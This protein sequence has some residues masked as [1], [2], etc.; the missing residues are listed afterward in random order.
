VS[1]SPDTLVVVDCTDAKQMQVLDTSSGKVIGKIVH[2]A[3]V[4]NVYLNQH[5][6][7]PQERLLAYSDRNRDLFI[8]ALHTTT[9]TIMV[10]SGILNVPTYKLNSHVESFIFNDETNVL[11][12]LADGRIKFWYHPDVAFIDKDLL[13]LTT[14]SSEATEYGRSAQILSYTGNRVSVRKVDGSILF[15]A[16]T[17]DVQ[18]L[19]ELSRGGKWDECTRLCRHQKSTFL[20]AT[21]SSMALSKKQLDT[22]EI[23]LAELNE[24]AKVEYI[25]YI[26]KIPSEEGRQAEL[27]LYRRQP[28]EAEK[29]LLQASPPLIYR[30]IKLNINLF[31]WSRAVDLAVKHKVHIDT[32]LA[33]RQKYLDE[34]QREETNQKFVQLFEKT[35]IDW[36]EIIENEEKELE[37]E[38][39]RVN[40]GGGRK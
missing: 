7:G 34:F 33:Y 30:A 40:K 6:L 10:Q 24:V 29:I 25:Q 21:L 1:L 31:R 19:Y 13:P 5:N 37:D 38:S 11:V 3:E 14:T 16:S 2:T 22:A 12:G 23:A 32:V 8:S 39:K 9:I 35:K 26:K 28:D 27:V 20:W 36:N 18:F 17:P 15:T 4:T